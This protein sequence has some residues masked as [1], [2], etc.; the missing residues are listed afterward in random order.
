MRAIGA[1]LSG[2]VNLFLAIDL[3]FW[4][5]DVRT[6]VHLEDSAF[7]AKG[8]TEVVSGVVPIHGS[9]YAMMF[10]SRPSGFRVRALL[11]RVLARVGQRSGLLRVL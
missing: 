11:V 5:K 1:I 10:W 4:L 7:L 3:S 6:G 9:G 8:A 2:S